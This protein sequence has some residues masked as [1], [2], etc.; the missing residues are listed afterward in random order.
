MS[1]KERTMKIL[2]A[3]SEAVPFCN[4]RPCGCGGLLPAALAAQGADVAVVLPLYQKVKEKF[5]DQL[6][7]ESHLWTWLA[8]QLLQAVL[9]GTGRRHLV[10]LDNE[11]YFRRRSCTATW[12]TA[13]GSVFSRAVVRMLP[14]V[15][16]GGHP[17]QRLADRLVPIYLKDERAGGAVPVSGPCSP[18]II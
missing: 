14:E 18:F 8:P 16:A 7:F 3:A 12:T 15:L 10:L 4:R 17:L 9:H 6:H 5:S 13:G 11:Q 2:Y 1:V